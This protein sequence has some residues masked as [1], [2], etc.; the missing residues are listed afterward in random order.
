MILLHC[1]VSL[2][3][4]IKHGYLLLWR[5]SFPLKMFCNYSLQVIV[6]VN[7]TEIG[8]TYQSI[9]TKRGT[10]T[11]QTLLLQVCL[12]SYWRK[13]FLISADL[14][15]I[16]LLL[17]WTRKHQEN[18][19]MGH[20]DWK[21]VVHTRESYEDKCSSS[22]LLLALLSVVYTSPEEKWTQNSLSIY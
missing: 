19:F 21:I 13:N 1:W 14:A 15:V 22:Q 7:L 17:M 6:L 5:I 8:F 20:L 12:K 10:N 18:Q 9:S 3:I 11:V 16:Q 4:I 2:L